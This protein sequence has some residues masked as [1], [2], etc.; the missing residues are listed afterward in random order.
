MIQAVG[1]DATEID[2]FIAWTSYPQAKLRRVFTASELQYSFAVSVSC[3]QRLALRFAVKEAFFK[4]V[5]TLHGRHNMSFLAMSR[6][7]GVEKT[8]QGALFLQINW[9]VIKAAGLT[10]DHNRL[11]LHV[12]ATHTKTTAFACVIIEQTG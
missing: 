9:D 5:S 1:T 6:H 2:R 3:A 11:R 10:I 4:A 12:S 8:S 7:I